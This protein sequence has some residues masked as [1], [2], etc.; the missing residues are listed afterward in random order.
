MLTKPITFYVGVVTLVFVI[1][2]ATK[3]KPISIFV[4][5]YNLVNVGA[6]FFISAALSLLI[7]WVINRFYHDRGAAKI[8]A[9]AVYTFLIFSVLFY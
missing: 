3:E 1:L 9:L 6:I 8:A 4:L 2:E 5:S 7:G